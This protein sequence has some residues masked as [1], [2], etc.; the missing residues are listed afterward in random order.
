[1]TYERQGSFIIQTA[2]KTFWSHCKNLHLSSKQH[3]V[4]CNF[5]RKN[6][7]YLLL[8]ISFV[9]YLIVWKS[10]SYY[11]HK[12]WKAHFEV[13]LFLFRQINAFRIESQALRVRVESWFGRVRA[14]SQKLLSHFESLAC[15]LE[16]NKMKHFLYVALFLNTKMFTPSCSK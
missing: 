12:K 1:M 2:T 11:F 3:V 6:I 9:E 16:S 4:L 7:V 13:F 10:V 5:Y 15:N 14:W 8:K